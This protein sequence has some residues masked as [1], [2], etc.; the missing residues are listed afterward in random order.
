MK[1]TGI[2]SFFG[3]A[4]ILLSAVTIFSQT[5]EFRADLGRAFSR[6][7]VVS[8]AGDQ[9]VGR[10]TTNR[11]IR[12]TGSRNLEITL[13]PH[14]MRSAGFKAQNAGFDGE[15]TVERAAVTTF[16][17]RVDGDSA[18]E[19]RLNMIN[20]RLEGFIK[21]RGET[22]FVEPAAKYS[23][24]ASDELVIY[25]AEDALTEQSFACGSSM[26]EK[27]DRGKSMVEGAT[28]QQFPNARR[29]EIATD[30]DHEYVT[31]LGG[32]TQANQEILGIL[33]TIEGMYADE[34]GLAFSV[35][36]QHTW[37]TVDSFAGVNTEQTARNFQAYW[38]TN[39]PTMAYPR[40]AAH[41]F[42]G[43]SNVQSQGWAFIGVICRDA[44][45]S[46][47]ISGYVSWAPGKYLLTAHELGHNVGANHADTMSNC[48][49]TLM[50]SQLSGATPL[51]FC[52]AS[53]DEVDGFLSGNGSCITPGV[54]CPN[55]MDGDGKADLGIFRPNGAFGGEWWFQ[56]SL[57]GST[58]AAQFGLSTDTLTPA[59]YTGDG[60]TDIAFFRPHTG[61]W[62]ILRSDDFSFYAFPFGT[63]GDIPTPADFDADG[64]VDAAVFRASSSTWFINRSSGGTEIVNFGSPSDKPVAGD[65]DGDGKADIAVFRNN[66]GIGEWWIKRSSDQ[67]VFAARF[68]SA[69]DKAVQGDFTGDGKSDIA[70]WRPSNGNWYVLRSEDGSFY[71]FPFGSAGDIPVAGDYDGDGRSD[72]AVFRPN[73][74]T[75][76]ASRSTAGTLIQQFGQSGDL[77][78]QSAYVR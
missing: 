5:A 70:L 9:L 11:K 21:S 61:F 60:K 13:M 19:V 44:A 35:T 8:V 3:L 67:E 72:A 53:R 41:L 45:S 68:G 26:V 48:S 78:L 52:Q 28:A 51:S 18:S 50:V 64:S 71:S 16:R 58:G 14:D 62:Y 39:F 69:T 76:Y 27:I 59:D 33:N 74:S 38:N 40:D 23:A 66:G 31:V 29:I 57:D 42:S 54:R 4:A 6:F 77:P 43:K 63:N 73:S 65:Y 32:V 56:R 15:T 7:E 20:G 36:F 46:Y 37:T 75:W 24:W 17:G 10:S 12:F 55:D 34:L 22:V 49:N 25:R 47:G 30:A 2:T 1:K